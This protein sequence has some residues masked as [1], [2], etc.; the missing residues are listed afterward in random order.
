MI[1]TMLL[2]YILENAVF[3]YA[4]RNRDYHYRG[5][6]SKIYYSFLE[7]ISYIS[8]VTLQRDLGGRH[9][10]RPAARVVCLIFATSMVIIVSTYTAV[11]A[12]QS[13]KNQ[14][15]EPF[16]GSQDYRVSTLF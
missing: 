6:A 16:R 12:A 10:I 9:P 1:F 3:F 2:S 15:K 4:S 11:L 13:L 14:E 7:S 5:Q 8:G